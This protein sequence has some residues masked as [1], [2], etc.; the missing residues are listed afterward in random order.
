MEFPKTLY[1]FFGIHVPK[2]PCKIWGLEHSR[3]YPKYTLPLSEDYG[4]AIHCYYILRW[5]SSIILCVANVWHAVQQLLRCCCYCTAAFHAPTS[6]ATSVLQLP[7]KC[8]IFYGTTNT[9]SILQLSCW[10]KQL[11]T[12]KNWISIPWI[13]LNVES[14]TAASPTLSSKAT[15]LLKLCTVPPRTVTSLLCA[16]HIMV[17]LTTASIESTLHGT[18]W[19]LHPATT[20]HGL[21]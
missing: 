13:H 4:L 3:C 10:E 8:C 15:A 20:D 1:R 18:N 21:L 16:A 11:K 7:L 6:N 12:P 17:L 9:A 14:L 5:L 19:K 2:P